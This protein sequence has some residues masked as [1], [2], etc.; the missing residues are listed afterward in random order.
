MAFL[1]CRLD[2]TQRIFGVVYNFFK[3]KAFFTYMVFRY[4]ISGNNFELFYNSFPDYREKKSC[5]SGYTVTLVG[6]K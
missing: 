5:N 4:A 3:G 6:K 1:G 2:K